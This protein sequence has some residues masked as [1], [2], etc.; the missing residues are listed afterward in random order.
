MS[1]QRPGLIG[2]LLARLQ[3]EY[4][5]TELEAY[6]R[7]GVDV[8]ALTEDLEVERTKWNLDELDSW[9]VPEATQA[10]FL[11]AWNA[12]ALQVLGDRLLDADYESE[13]AT[14]GYLPP[15]TARQT[16]GFY[17]QVAEWLSRARQASASPSFRLDVHVPAPGGRSGW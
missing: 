12:F 14:V 2:R 3:G 17:S 10:A 1:E 13:P 16:L 7:A 6:R 4:P 15:V 8:Y 5:A 11:C 9:S